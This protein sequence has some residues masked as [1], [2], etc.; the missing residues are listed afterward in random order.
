MALGNNKDGHHVNE[1]STHVDT[2]LGPRAVVVQVLYGNAR[3]LSHA[4]EHL[5][6]RVSDAPNT[7][8][9]V[10]KVLGG[11]VALE[12]QQLLFKSNK[13]HECF[14][15]HQSRSAS[16]SNAEHIVNQPG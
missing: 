1:V 14:R 9:Q 15:H 2:A 7:V 10:G 5:F 11:T 6:W 4:V 8:P 12:Q 13:G 3:G 16:I